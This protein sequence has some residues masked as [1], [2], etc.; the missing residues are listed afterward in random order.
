MKIPANRNVRK[1]K[2]IIR[3][4]S[5]RFLYIVFIGI[6]TTTD[7]VLKTVLHINGDSGNGRIST[8][9]KIYR[10]HF[11]SIHAVRIWSAT[12]KTNIQ[13]F[14]YFCRFQFSNVTTEF[15]IDRMSAI[16]NVRSRF[17]GVWRDVPTDNSQCIVLT[18]N[19]K[20][21]DSVH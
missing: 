11:C 5:R 9:T 8:M 7:M 1:T 20:P 13:P 15:R 16:H 19:G 14:L 2:W 17:S 4:M 10:H 3:S 18:V 12:Q 21:D 6:V